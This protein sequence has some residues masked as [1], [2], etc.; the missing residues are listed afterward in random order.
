MNRKFLTFILTSICLLFLACPSIALGTEYQEA[1]DA[2]YR[3]DYKTSYDLILPLAKK[4]FAP[5]QYSLGVM[6]ERGKG[7][8]KSYKKAK[9]W[10]QFAADQGFVRAQNKLNYISKKKFQRASKGHSKTLAENSIHFNK[11]NLKDGLNALNKKEY[12]TA[13]NL[14]LELAEKGIVQAQYNLG[15]IYGKGKGVSKNYSKAYRW[16]KL[17]AN[18]GHGKSQTNLGWMYEMGKGV[19]KDVYKATKWYQLASDQ[20]L[21]KAQEKLNLLLNKTKKYSQENSPRSTKF[22]KLKKTKNPNLSTDSLLNEVAEAQVYLGLGMKFEVGEEVPQ[23]YDEA[24]RWYR[25]AADLGLIEAQEKLSLLLDKTKEHFPTNSLMPREFAKL[26]ENKDPQA[27]TSSLLDNAA[28][29]QIY[30]G[31]GIRFETGEEVPQD[32]DE[33][34]RWYRLAADF[35]LIEAQ[36]KLSSLL[37]KTK[38][39]LQENL[40]HSKKLKSLKKIG[41]TPKTVASLNSKLNQVKLKKVQV[42]KVTTQFNAET[43]QEQFSSISNNLFVLY[44]ENFFYMSDILNL[45]VDSADALTKANDYID[46]KFESFGV[47]LSKLKNKK[48]SLRFYEQLSEPRVKDKIKQQS[49]Q[50]K[51]VTH[52]A[53]IPQK[54]I[55]KKNSETIISKDLVL[56]YLNKWVGAW[57]KKDL[58]LYFSFYSKVFKGLGMSHSSWMISRQAAFKKNTNISI[59]LENIRISINIDSVAINFTQT[60]TSDSYSDVG[61]K[62]LLWGRN[63]SNWRIVKETWVPY[64]KPHI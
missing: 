8:N 37:N 23:D 9:K 59:Q 44:P 55:D 64:K 32:Y 27:L 62:E 13:H 2:Y 58:E 21:V 41:D 7:V 60:F 22:K 57:E 53:K 17:A 14:F 1:I 18:Q 34:I 47:E 63:G 30:L 36:E 15:L 51:L 50:K 54:S 46:V 45:V 56:I 43:K 31:L 6:Y 42:T 61:I 10:F 33:A 12:K 28:E 52:L 11:K 26:K 20:G 38:K 48:K 19:P 5:A 3:K 49:I 25:L 4:G 16:W 24:I 35:G 39:H 29:A 40:S